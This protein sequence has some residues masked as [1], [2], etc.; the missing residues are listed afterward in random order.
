[1]LSTH[2]KNLACFIFVMEGV[3]SVLSAIDY[4]DAHL[5]DDISVTAGLMI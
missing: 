3:G 5:Y 4:T 2:L 1:M